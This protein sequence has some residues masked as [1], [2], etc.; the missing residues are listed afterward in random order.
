MGARALGL[1]LLLLVTACGR[2]PPASLFPTADA[3]LSR[4][5]ETY[6]CSRGVK[7]DAKL[8]YFGEEGRV[9]G[10]V[11]YLSELPDRVRFDIISPFGAMVS[12]LTADGR[13]FALYDL[14][15]KQFLHGPAN[16]CNLSRFTG[17]P[18]PPH[19]LV[20]L[21][22][23]E[24]PVLV[25]ATEAATIAWE[26][27]R[28]ALTIPSK[29]QATEQIFLEPLPEDFGLHWQK[30]RVRVLEV[31]VEQ[32]DVVLYRAELAGHRPGRTSPPLVD[33]DGID[34]P[35]LPSGPEC[36]APIPSRIRLEV[37]NSEKELILS[38]TEV[39]HNPPLADGA[40]RQRPPGGVV[41]RSS[42]CQQ[43]R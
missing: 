22:R 43:E 11:L 10:S 17:I 3:A 1:G 40:F 15:Q 29:H 18:I 25:H 32:A 14:R 23:G 37:P 7:G 28:Y 19:A 2:P 27:G 5:R 9:R 20:Q 8:T 33:A 26:S 21:L 4:M 41:I 30:Q 42:P 16:T 39:F 38:N 36:S 12:T 13:D 35:I 31:V 24:A 34:P 6:A